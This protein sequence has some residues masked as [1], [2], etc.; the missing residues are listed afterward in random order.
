MTITEL[1]SEINKLNE[2]IGCN[3]TRTASHLNPSSVRFVL[4]NNELIKEIK[5]GF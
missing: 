1:L 2:E 4:D 5:N 3:G